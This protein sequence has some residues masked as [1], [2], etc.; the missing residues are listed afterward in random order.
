M[1]VASKRRYKKLYVVGG[2]GFFDT[3]SGFF[4][5]L[6]TSNAAKQVAS[7]A[8]SVGKDAARQIG[9]H[10]LDTGKTAA[11]NVGKRLV[12]KVADKLFAPKITQRSKEM[13]A[14]LID[15]DVNINNLLADGSGIK[16][17]AIQDFVRRL[18][19]GGLKIA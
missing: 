17:I 5:R 3:I 19:G 8:L 7:T 6:F 13:L 9:K 11:I 14:S 10:A 2:A 4:K 1:L 12:D 16:A 15:D 18:N